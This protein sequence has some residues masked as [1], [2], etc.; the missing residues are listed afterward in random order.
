MTPLRFLTG[1]VGAARADAAAR[2]AKELARRTSRPVDLR[3]TAGYGELLDAV[4]DRGADFAWLPPAVLVRAEE[5]AGVTPVL[6]GIR[7][8]DARFRGAIFVRAD[9]ALTELDQLRQG[10]VAWVDR[11]SCAGYLFPRLFLRSQGWDPDQDFASQAHYGTHGAVVEAVESGVVD[12]GATFVHQEDAEVVGTGWGLSG[13]NDRM[14]VL[15]LTEPI[16]ADAIA[17]LEA[18]PRAVREVVAEAIGTMHA[19]PEGRAALAGL[20]GVQRFEPTLPARYDAVRS[21]M[22]ASG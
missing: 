8:N 21:A 7:A 17:T 4:L 10:R 19:D 20:F 6:A 11:N 1:P 9:A 14:R 22:R 12:A 16:P 18:T 13:A 5:L 3:P 15:A 2:F